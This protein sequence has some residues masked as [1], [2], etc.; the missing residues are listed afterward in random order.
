MNDLENVISG[1]TLTSTSVN[2][3]LLV[4]ASANE[5]ISRCQKSIYKVL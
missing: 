1:D 2:N 5:E 3:Q 4:V